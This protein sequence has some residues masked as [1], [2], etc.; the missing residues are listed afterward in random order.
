[1]NLAKK[2]KGSSSRNAIDPSADG[3]RRPQPIDRLDPIIDLASRFKVDSMSLGE[4][5]LVL[6]FF[7]ICLGISLL[8][9]GLTGMLFLLVDLVFIAPPLV[10]LCKKMVIGMETARV[11]LREI[12]EVL[13]GREFFQAVKD[14]T[15]RWEE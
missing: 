11:M 12:R 13:R 8:I 7:T 2:M 10:V 1:M 4:T 14:L 6:S 5:I 15:G 9:G 3:K